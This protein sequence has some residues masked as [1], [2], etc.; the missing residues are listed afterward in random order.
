MTISPVVS[1]AEVVPVSYNRET[2]GR[3]LSLDFY[4]GLTVAGMIL[5]TNP[6]SWDYVYSPLKH[7]D[8]NGVT[9]TDMIFP[10]FLF[11]AGVSM[12]YSFAARRARGVAPG[13]IFRHIVIRSLSLIVLGVILNGFPLYDWHNLRI[14]GIL[15]RIGLCC[16]GAGAFYLALARKQSSEERN[17]QAIAAAIFALLVTYW[18]LMRF[19][20]APGF[21]V[22]RLDQ[23]GNLEGYIDRAIFGP[24]H[25]WFY[26]G[27]MWDP[28]GLLSTMTA[29]CNMLLGILTGEWMRSRRSDG[30]DGAK[31]SGM[32]IA[33]A[34]LMV[35]GVALNPWIPIN[36]KIWTDSFMLFSGGFSLLALAFLSW[37]IDQ[38]G[39]RRGGWRWGIGP[40][41]IFGSNAILAFA[42]ATVL[43]PL[44]RML[45]FHNAS[46]K[47]QTIH[48]AVFEFL[49][50]WM[51]PYMA[52][53]GYA[54]LFATFNLVIVW[55][56]YRKRIFLR[57]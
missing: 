11:I 17:T 46:G 3:L 54:L 15:Q 40:G 23:A 47:L 50:R 52:S 56:F 7:A 6:G 34:L 42:L 41:R 22:G 51:S 31:L 25:L 19:V 48:G 21:G 43:Y 53:L 13:Q 57:L 1:D 20:P 12:A 38:H 36:K 29:C 33:G 9:P 39:R 24:D 27:R 30:L 2:P 45:Q 26:G 37:L 14:P 8:W 44:E 32:A 16:L 28:E 55:L 49:A 5:V 10:S 4:R 35:A 18:A